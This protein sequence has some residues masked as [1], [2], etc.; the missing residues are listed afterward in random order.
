MYQGL[1]HLA[2]KAGI[3]SINVQLIFQGDAVEYDLSRPE[4]VLNQVPHFAIGNEAGKIVAVYSRATL[5]D[6][7]VHTE[8]MAGYEVEAIMKVS[9]SYK[10]YEAGKIPTCPWVSNQGEMYRKT[11]LKRHLK[12]L[13][14]NTEELGT[15]ID[16]DNEAHGFRSW[17]DA[18]DIQEIEMLIEQTNLEEKAYEHLK[19]RLATIKYK[20]E[21]Q[22][23]KTDFINQYI[24]NVPA[25]P[26]SL[27][28][29]NARIDNDLFKEE[30]R[31]R[32]AK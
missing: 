12:Y 31:E 25:T 13:G 2:L 16:L 24:D 32:R 23:M 28:E 30:E 21:A 27:K 4:K 11:C 19:M 29:I 9:E 22:R 18:S 14:K 5:D 17:V 1:L 3:K 15:A 26:Q 7:S 8:L 10:A 6:G 20:D